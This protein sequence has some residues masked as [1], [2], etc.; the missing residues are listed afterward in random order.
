MDKTINGLIYLPNFISPIEQQKLLEI[1]GES[2]WLGDLNRRVQHHGYK[3]D[4]KK[5]GID[6]SMKLDKLPEW[7]TTLSNKIHQQKLMPYLPDQLIVNEYLPG[8]GIAPHIDC[9]PCFEGVIASLSL[10]AACVM[11]F[12][13]NYSNEKKSILL[14]A[15]SLLVLGDEARYGWKHG[16]AARKSD[17]YNGLK[18]LRQRRVSLTFRKVI[19]A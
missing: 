4:Y 7:A 5:R 17:M 13:N 3:Y 16:I 12:T 8:Q 15:Q 11:D 2:T 9:E 14:E 1:I 10:G 6:I 19:L 18:M